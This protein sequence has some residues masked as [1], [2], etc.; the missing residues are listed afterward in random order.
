MHYKSPILEI[1]LMKQWAFT[2]IKQSIV[3]SVVFLH[4]PKLYSNLYKI[5]YKINQSGIN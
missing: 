1:E 3:L 2:G 4:V 5:R